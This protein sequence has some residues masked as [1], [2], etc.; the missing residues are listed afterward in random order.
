MSEASRRGEQDVRA[1]LL[2]HAQERGVPNAVEI[3]P[4][5]P[6]SE[7]M[8]AGKGEEAP[9][10]SRLPGERAQAPQAPL[11][12]PIPWPRVP[13]VDI[14]LVF[15]QRSAPFFERPWVFVEV[16]TRNTIYALDSRLFCIEVIDRATHRHLESHPLIGA[17]LVGGQLRSGET[18]EI[19]H[20]FPRPG[21]EAVFEQVKG[22]QVRFSRTSPVVRVVLRLRVLHVSPETGLPTWEELTRQE[23]ARRQ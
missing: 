10:D 5:Q 21:A 1:T 14:D 19:S 3:E 13:A 4:I 7:S 17:R 20:P 15:E 23:Q 2:G 18:L 22:R 8:G 12:D 16:W 6:T 11:P 9:E